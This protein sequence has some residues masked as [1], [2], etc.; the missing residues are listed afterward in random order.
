[1]KTIIHILLI[2]ILCL[3]S[4]FSYMFAKNVNEVLSKKNIK[5]VNNEP[6]ICVPFKIVPD[7]SNVENE[8]N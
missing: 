4:Y 6:L 5:I 8:N 3:V 1:M 7:Y 2:L